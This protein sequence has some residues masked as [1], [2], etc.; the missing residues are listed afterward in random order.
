ML[1]HLL[2]HLIPVKTRKNIVIVV[3]P[4]NSIIEDQL[5]VLRD[6]NIVADVIQVA[7]NMWKLAEDLFEKDESKNQLL[8]ESDELEVFTEPKAKCILEELVNGNTSI[9]FAYSEALL[10]K[11]GKKM[12]GSEI[13]Q[14]NVVRCVVNEAHCVELWYV[15]YSI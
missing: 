14:D 3:C 4:L 5:G 11:E 9:L 2:P 13:F 6:R 7:G 10:S 1:F 8:V 15:L 12:M